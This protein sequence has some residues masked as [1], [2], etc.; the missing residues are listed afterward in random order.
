MRGTAPNG[1]LA[2]DGR[3]RAGVAR[4]AARRLLDADGATFVLR[5][6]DRC[7]NPLMAVLGTLELLGDEPLPTIAEE[8]IGM[9]KGNADRMLHIAN[10]LIDL[11][12]QRSGSLVMRPGIT[13]T[14]GIAPR[15]ADTAHA[16]AR[17]A[18]V[19]LVIEVTDHA[20]TVDPQRICPALVNL[21]TRAVDM[22]KSSS[23]K[24][25][26]LGQGVI[27]VRRVREGVLACRCRCIR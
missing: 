27:A 17:A 16:V 12:L 14:G 23:A 2:C 10:N 8:S 22:K 24:V 11:D 21:V 19:R 25:K 9:A 6:G 1:Q 7:R 4:H 26:K 18:D 13:T 3:C 20:L 5:D 15:V